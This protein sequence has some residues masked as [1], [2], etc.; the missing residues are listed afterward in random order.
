MS[1]VF[2]WPTYRELWTLVMD[3]P[4]V[5]GYF[6]EEVVDEGQRRIRVDRIE[7]W[8][9]L[10]LEVTAIPPQEN[11]TP[12]RVHLLVDSPRSHTRVAIPLDGEEE[13]QGT[14]DLRREYLAGPVKLV[15]EA[16]TTVDGRTRL[17]GRSEEWTLV[18]DAGEAPTPPGAPPFPILWTDFRTPDAPDAARRNPDALSFMEPSGEPRLYLNDGI[19]GFRALLHADTARLERRRAR[20]LLAGQVARTAWTTL[21]RVAV[22]EVQ[23]SAEDDVPVAPDQPIF[24]Q[25]L[26]GVAR[27][28]TG[29]SDLEDLVMHI[30]SAYRGS[31]AEQAALWSELDA[32]IDR[33]CGLP[34]AT[35][36]LVREAR[37][38]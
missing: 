21:L 27:V 4:M 16:T 38:V 23:M 13:W 34:D 28:T 17:L 2:A 8:K 7:D 9:R 18:V 29:V 22:A 12:G 3:S 33:L 30:A 11:L 31:V 1:T 10:V 35:E 6:H 26:E 24:R 15:A 37:N 5:D 32:A 19:E 36:S 20:D 14:A 25:A